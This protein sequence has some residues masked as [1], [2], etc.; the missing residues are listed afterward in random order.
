MKKTIYILSF[1]ILSLGIWLILLWLPPFN[2]SKG[3]SQKTRYGLNEGMELVEQDLGKEGKRYVVEDA[4]G[5]EIFVIPLRNCLLD[6]RFRNG[7]L[8]FREQGTLREGFIDRQGMVTFIGTG[9]TDYKSVEAQASSSSLTSADLHSAEQA[10]MQGNTADYQST[11]T[12]KEYG[13]TSSPKAKGEVLS[14]VSLKQMAQSNPF[15]KEASKIM[16]GKLNETDAQCRHT[17]LNYCEH[18]RTAYITKDIDF[19]KQVFS[20]QALIIVGNVVKPT[21]S[22]NKVQAESKV[23]YAIHSKHDY[24][25]RLSKVF[26]TNKAIN[27]KF[28]D[29]RIMRHPTMTGIYGVTLRQQYK[30]DQYSD[31]GYLFLLWD[32]RNKSM[33]LIHIR[34]W[35]PTSTIDSNGDLISIQDFNLQ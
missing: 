15:Y 7:Q 11:E 3:S 19:L 9:A 6:T 4:N 2:K 21:T 17:I 18:F 28:S 5:K 23:T 29:F 20:D 31:D 25:N 14:Q 1:L 30:S 27:V 34:T 26:A 33:P 12:S 16:Q 8:R 24:I 32:F 35:Q 10:G 22:D 13:V